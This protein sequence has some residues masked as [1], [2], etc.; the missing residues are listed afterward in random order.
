MEREREKERESISLSPLEGGKIK[1]AKTV[2]DPE[3]IDERDALCGPDRPATG[4][5]GKN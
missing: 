5:E 3:S 2:I 4:E 1:F